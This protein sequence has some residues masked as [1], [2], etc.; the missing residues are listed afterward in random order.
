MKYM[1]F[2]V[3]LAIVVLMLMIALP[4]A[5]DDPFGGPPSRTSGNGGTTWAAIYVANTCS[6]KITLPAGSATWFKFDTWKSVDT[7][8]Y[9][10]DVP[11]FGAAYLY[12]NGQTGPFYN[13]SNQDSV[14]NS[15]RLGPY[16]TQTTPNGR[17]NLNAGVANVGGDGWGHFPGNGP[18]GQY[19]TKEQALYDYWGDVGAAVDQGFIARLYDPDYITRMAYQWPT[20]NNALLTTRSGTQAYQGQ[21][22]VISLNSIT[23]DRYSY[24]RHYDIKM[25]DGQTHLLSGRFHWDGWGY[26]KVYNAMAWDNDAMVCTNYI[27]RDDYNF[28][29][30]VDFGTAN[31]DTGSHR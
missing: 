23:G 25:A 7:E 11:K 1:K 27:K 21:T 10:D 13:Q 6:A 31:F 28:N 8:V 3:P 14:D 30:S 12:F 18:A 29:A 24:L 5:A 26:I 15:V 19:Q 20:P 22:N 4:A 17:T 9:V 2:I 16:A